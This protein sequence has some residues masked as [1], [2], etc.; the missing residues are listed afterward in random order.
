MARIDFSISELCSPSRADAQQVGQRV[1]GMHAHQ[2]RPGRREVALD[3]RQ[4]LDRLHRRLVDVQVEG[5]AEAAFDAS[6]VATCL[7]M[8]SW[9]QAVA[10]QVL[11]GADLEAV[12]LGEGD[13]VRHARHGAVVVHDLADD[14]GR[15]EAGQP[16]EIDAGLRVPGAD[17][18]AA[19]AR[20]QREHVAGRD[21]VVEV[22]GRVDGRGDGAG[23]IVRGDAGGDAL[24]RLDRDREGGAVARLVL[25]RHVLE[26]KLVGALARQR[27]ADQAAAVLGHEVDG[28][29]RRHLRGDDEVALVL[30]VLGIDQDDHAAVAQILEDLVDGREEALAFR[31]GDPSASS[32]FTGGTPSAAPRSAQRGRLRG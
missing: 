17:Q 32:C 16:R 11:D 29:G 24:A 2:H 3:Q 28:I 25:A 14:A 23:A 4:V 19:L 8:R 1:D 6:L 30:A 9:L 27:Q 21:D 20:D 13:E 15:I 7:T 31:V 22:L 12:P 18:H 5:A 26:A 10:D